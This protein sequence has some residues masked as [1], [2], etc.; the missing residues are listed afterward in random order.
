MYEQKS[1]TLCPL[2]LFHSFT[3]KYVTIV[4]SITC[5]IDLA[6]INHKLNEPEADAIIVR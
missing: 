1:H 5:M 6:L 3:V 2:I 4:N